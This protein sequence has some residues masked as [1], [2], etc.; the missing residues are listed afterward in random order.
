[1]YPSNI[2][3]NSGCLEHEVLATKFGCNICVVQKFDEV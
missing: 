3:K 1:M 2:S